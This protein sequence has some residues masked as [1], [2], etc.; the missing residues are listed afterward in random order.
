MKAFLIGFLFI[1]AL[2]ILSGLGILLLPFLLVLTFFLR[3]FIGFALVILAIW[4][5]G[6]FIIL[7]WG[8][9]RV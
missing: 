5:L 7:V 2:A 1:I 9:M 3:I 4:L 8:R 6:K